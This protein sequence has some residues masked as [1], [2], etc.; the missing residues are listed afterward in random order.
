[1][2]PLLFGRAIE[3]VKYPNET[4]PLNSHARQRRGRREWNTSLSVGANFFPFVFVFSHLLVIVYSFSFRS[5]VLFVNYAPS[6]RSVCKFGYSLLSRPFFY[7]SLRVYQR[8]TMLVA[9]DFFSRFHQERIEKK[10][11]PATLDKEP[12]TLDPRQKDRP[13]KSF[14]RGSRVDGSMSR[15]KL[16]NH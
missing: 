16:N 13:T 15:V 5:P 12:S 6:L 2:T 7:Q 4:T 3:S 11:L 10:L 1:M 9:V 8:V 14:C